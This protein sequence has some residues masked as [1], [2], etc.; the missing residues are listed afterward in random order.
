MLALDVQLL[1]NRYDAATSDRAVPEWPP[2]PARAFCALVAGARDTSEWDALRWLERQPPPD[3]IASRHAARLERSGYVV[4]N[5]RE[6]TGGSQF[7]PGRTNQLRTR[8]AAQ[9]T[10]DR[11]R[12][13][14][15]ESSAAADI[16]DALD[17]LAARIPYLGRST[18]PVLASISTRTREPES[19]LA[20]FQPCDLTVAQSTLRVPFPGYLDELRAAY[21]EDRPSW[22]ISRLLGYRIEE[23]EPSEA[24]PATSP[25]AELIVLRLPG[26]RPDGRLIPRITAALREALMA[27]TADPLPAALHG[28]DLD[29]KPHIAFV[30]LPDAG[31]HKMA[32]GQLVGLGVAL[33]EIEFA[34]RRKVVR[35][36]LPRAEEST[37]RLDVEGIGSFDVAAGHADNP[38]RGAT[39]ERW[40]AAARTWVTVTPMAF[41]RHPKKGDDPADMV[42]R[43]CQLAGYPEPE[44]VEISRDPL[45]WGAVRFAPNDLPGRL[46]SKMI[47]HVRLHFA[48]AVTGPVLVGAGRY[49]GIGLF[50]PE[51][52][53]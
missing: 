1:D 44:T 23:A 19:G 25:F 24:P 14:W 43:S 45:T 42:A 51:R 15:T 53:R 16:A 33:P 4:T 12:F 20:R 26:F 8:A 27:R 49:L 13:E 32:R 21:A 22:E 5:R 34:E 39:A 7:H 30:G 41:D 29:D 48:S 9:P 35:A 31:L 37:W 52:P 47:R 2:H 46:R 18:T 40:S 10:N 38:P 36:L 11:V 6:A 17:H 50:S 3:V 28:H